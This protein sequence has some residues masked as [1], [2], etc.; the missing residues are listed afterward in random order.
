MPAFRCFRPAQAQSQD[1]R[2]FSLVG[3]HAGFFVDATN[4]W[5]TG[6]PQMS[7]PG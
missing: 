4:S 6:Q 3:E 7:P 1:G 2:G 5:K